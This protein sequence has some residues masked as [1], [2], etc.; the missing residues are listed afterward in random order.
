[1]V[2]FHTHKKIREHK[3]LFLKKKKKIPKHGYA[4]VSEAKFFRIYMAKT[5]NN[6]KN[7]PIFQENFLR[8]SPFVCENDPK[9]WKGVSRRAPAI[10]SRPSK[11]NVNTPLP[12][13]YCMAVDQ[14]MKGLVNT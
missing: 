11:E 7:G 10:D 9:K 2:A 8:M 14:F 12:G 3:F 5:K 1:M 6:E 4:F 13:G